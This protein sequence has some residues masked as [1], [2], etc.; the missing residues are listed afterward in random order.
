MKNVSR[1][2]N[3][4]VYTNSLG[5]VGMNSSKAMIVKNGKVIQL[6]DV[7]VS[8]HITAISQGTTGYVLMVNE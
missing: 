5:D 1:W 8:D 3:S 4:G 2:D 6:K 7:K